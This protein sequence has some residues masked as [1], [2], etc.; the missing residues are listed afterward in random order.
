[1]LRSGSVASLVLLCFASAAAQAAPMGSVRVTDGV[2]R[3][4]SLVERAASRRCWK[5]GGKT[6]CAPARQAAPQDE[7]Y[8][9]RYGNPRP[10]DLRFGS[11]EWW[12][13]MDRERR[14][15][16]PGDS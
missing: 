2:S 11:A 13:A 15:G 3:H 14:G 1:M 4:G 7:G 8:G 16:Y 10:E 12:R 6:Q 9:G 5:E